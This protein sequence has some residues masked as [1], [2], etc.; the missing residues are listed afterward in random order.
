[1]KLLLLLLI[2]PNILMAQTWVQVEDFPG[3]ERDDGICFTIGQKAYCGTGFD[4]G[5]QTTRDFYSFDFGSE[6]WSAIAALPVGERRQYAT[7]FVFNNQGYVF[8]GIDSAGNYLNDVWCYSPISDTWTERFGLPA[9]GRSGASAFVLSDTAYIVGGKTASNE[10]SNEVWAYVISSNGWL[11]KADFP[12][13][14]WR[15]IAF[16]YQGK[17]YAG[18]GRD[19]GWQTPNTAIYRYEPGIN[20]WALVPELDFEERTYAL[21]AS[22]GDFVYL[23]A[24]EGASGYLSSLQRINML[25]LTV[26]DLTSFSDDARRGGSAFTNGEDFFTVNGV[27][28]T[29][30]EKETWVARGA[31]AVEEPNSEEQAKVWIDGDQIQ[32]QAPDLKEFDLLDATGRCVLHSSFSSASITFLSRGCYFYR[33][34]AGDRT[35]L[36][37]VYID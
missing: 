16:S 33:A 31:L 19:D 3:S 29:Q 14:M 24:G 25:S 23:F 2:T 22:T 36:G 18:L 13:E 37:K 21:T 35:Y 1:M 5:F 8:G 9:L 28:S 32:V 4:A 17:G 20:T 7:S 12:D 15:G 11:Q 27:T 34:Q 26:D 10:A 30:R 6:T